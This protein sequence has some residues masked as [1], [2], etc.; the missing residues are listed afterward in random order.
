MVAGSMLAACGENDDVGTNVLTEPVIYVIQYTD[1]AGTHTIEVEDGDPYSIESIPQREGYD[2]TGLYDAEVGGTQYISASGSSL[3]PFTDKRN[4]VLFPQFTPKQYTLQ[5]D[6][7]GAPVTGERNYIVNYSESLPEL[8]RN[9]TLEHSTFSGWYTQPNCQGVQVA[10]EYGLL[11]DRAIVNSTNFDLTNPNGFIYLYAGFRV[12][13]FTVTFNFGSGIQSQEMQVDY[14]TSISQI[15]PNVRNSEGEAVLSWSTDQSGNN[16][17]TGYITSDTVLYAAEWAP[18]I[19]LDPNGGEDIL[20]VVAREGVSVSLPTTVRANYKFMGWLDEEGNIAEIA[21]MPAGGASLTATWQAM[22]VLNENG[23]AAVDDISLAVG[24][25]ITLPTPTRGGYIF[26]GW[27]TEDQNKYTA[28]SMPAASVVLKAG[29]YRAASKDKVFLNDGSYSDTVCR[30]TDVIYTNFNSYINFNEEMS[31]VDWSQGYNVT[32]N[33]HSDIRH[34]RW[35]TSS[36]YSY[37]EY[38]ATKEHISYY[39]QNV[40]SEAY[41]IDETILNHGKN[42]INT[43]LTS[44]DWTVTL[45]VPSNGIIYIA[46]AADEDRYT[47]NWSGHTSQTGWDMTNFYATIYYPDTTTLYL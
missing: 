28:T 45:T 10:D 27:Y 29:W 17:F 16:I 18:V 25:A 13:Q 20:P 7:Q 31:E 2:F 19:E 1:D 33:F 41:F 47:T 4:L 43:N 14:N 42:Q 30:I 21:T 12:Q 37:L 38:Y 15:V 26:A 40:I 32:I 46:L 5:L 22:I 6:Y 23:G 24:E 39:S 8:P 11:L 3:S 34:A 36:S 9:L 44:Q 35:R